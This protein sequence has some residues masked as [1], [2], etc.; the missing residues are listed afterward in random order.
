[1]DFTTLVSNIILSMREFQCNRNTTAQCVT[2]TQYVFDIINANSSNKVTVKAVYV[3]GNR[4]DL[5]SVFIQ[6]H[7][8]IVLDDNETIVDPSYDVF[9]LQNRIYCNNIKDVM[10]WISEEYKQHLTTQ[11]D[12]KEIIKTHIQFIQFAEMINIGIGLIGDTQ[13]YNDQAD[14]IESLYIQYI[15][16]YLKPAK[17]SRVFSIK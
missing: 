4:N 2:N 6:G 15:T 14:Y 7:L 9:S 13:F 17:N 5:S 11:Y 10:G 16:P 12:V 1:M 3:L 8:V